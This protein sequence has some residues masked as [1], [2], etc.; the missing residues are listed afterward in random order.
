M[1]IDSGAFSAW[2]KGKVI[3]IDEYI[4][5]LNS[6]SKYITVAASVDVI[7]GAPRSSEV[8]FREE[9]LKSG[10]DT[11]KN[12]LYMREKGEPFQ[13]GIETVHLFGYSLQI[14][15]SAIT[16]IDFPYESLF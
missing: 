1:F 14:L 15:L 6:I 7:P 8:P 10:E 5:F 16:A 13:W 3:D 12:F 4:S 11:W 9:I 2:T